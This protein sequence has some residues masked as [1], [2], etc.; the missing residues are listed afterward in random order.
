MGCDGGIDAIP[1]NAKRWRAS[2]RRPRGA[3][4]TGD[5]SSGPSS[6]ATPA[7]PKAVPEDSGDGRSCLAGR[8]AE[9]PEESGSLRP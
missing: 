7:V 4:R 6:I 2:L 9:L 5:V 8:L 3:G 1:W